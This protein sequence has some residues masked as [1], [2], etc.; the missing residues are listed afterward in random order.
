[1][2]RLREALQQ[3]SDPVRQQQA[4]S[5]KILK[6]AEPGPGGVVLYLFVMDPVVKNADYTVSKI[7]AEAF[8]TEL[9]DLWPRLRDAYA[10]GLHRLSLQVVA[11]VP[12]APVK[13]PQ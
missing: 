8:P 7:L 10:G 3:S 5:W 1:M 4:A 12:A 13:P 2:A 11:P 6:A 9:D